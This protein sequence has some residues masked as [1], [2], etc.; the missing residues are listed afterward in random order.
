M[1]GLLD[2][3]NSDLSGY[4]TLCFELLSTFKWWDG[5][6]SITCQLKGQQMTITRTVMK[7]AFGLS[8]AHDVIRSIQDEFNMNE[9]WEELTGFNN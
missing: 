5:A 7:Q 3:A 4:S 1:L 9:A 8:D 6:R 2:Y